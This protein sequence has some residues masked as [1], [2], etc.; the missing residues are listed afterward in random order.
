VWRRGGRVSRLASWCEISRAAPYRQ[1]LPRPKKIVSRGAGAPDSRR[2]PRGRHGVAVAYIG[3]EKAPA[4]VKARW[5][6][7]IF[8]VGSQN[9]IE[10]L[11]GAGGDALRSSPS[12]GMFWD[13]YKKNCLRRRFQ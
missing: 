9:V 10:V 7:P 8:V 2:S 13:P 1:Q 3:L 4:L 11:S 6:E 5:C 12:A